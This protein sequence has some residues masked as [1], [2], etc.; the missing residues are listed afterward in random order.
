MGNHWYDQLG[1]P[2]YTVI[3]KNGRERPATI[4]DAK[5][6]LFV[7]SVTTVLDVLGKPALTSWL[8]DQGILAALTL[9][10]NIG[11]G[12]A[13][14]LAR[15]KNDSKQQAKQAAE[16][17]D[18]IHN[19]LEC[20][21]TG[22]SVPARYRE[23]VAGTV[24][25]LRDA[26]PCVTDWIAERSFAHPLGFGGRTDLHSPSTGLVID[27]KSKDGDFSDGK[28]LAY[29]QHWQLAAYSRGLGL[30]RAEC[31]NVFVSRTHPGRAV[32]HKWSIGDIDDGWE[33]FACALKLWQCCTK[34]D[35]AFNSQAKVAA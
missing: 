18:R 24:M 28:K 9:S 15:V 29:D 31:G 12:D 17:G 33:V 4:R 6:A 14:Y 3:G 1:N 20:H 26:Y 34:Y 27:F 22:A 2:R 21:Y 10:R 23:H 32:V 25:A 35:S 8:V 30:P 13:E 7:P 5:A 19:A 11:E 16:E